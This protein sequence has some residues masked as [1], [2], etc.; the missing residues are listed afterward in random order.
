[1]SRK[2]IS[3]LSF[4]LFS[5]SLLAQTIDADDDKI[6]H[7]TD[8]HTLATKKTLVILCKKSYGAPSENKIVTQICQCQVNLLDRRYSMKQIKSYEKKYKGNGVGMLIDEDTLLKRQIKDCIATSKDMVM[9]SIPAYRQ[10]FINKCKDNIQLNSTKPLNDTLATVFCSCAADVLE[11]RKITLEKF[12]DLSDPSSF[13]YNEIAYKCGSPFLEASDFAKDWKASNRMDIVGGED[14]DSI[15][16]ISVMGMHKIKITIG[17]QT[18]IWMIDSGA[19]D[20]LVSEDYVNT[21]KKLGVIREMNFIGEGLYS[22]ADNRQVSCKRY[23][24]DSVHIGH[25]TINNI[26]I[27]TSRETKEFLMGKSLLNKFSEWSIDNKNNWL[28]LK[29]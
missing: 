13:L 9:T 10:S 17:N 7:T 25:F 4:I 24:I 21:L 20:L 5:S 16:I 23:K 18:R 11:K 15:T 12:D 8:G 14:V 26:I 27:A 6:I 3:T 1:M 19:S 28:I 22:T 29:K 2:I